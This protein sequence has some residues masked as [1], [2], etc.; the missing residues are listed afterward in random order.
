[1]HTPIH[2]AAP[3]ARQF[4]AKTICTPGLSR[5]QRLHT[6]LNGAARLFGRASGRLLDLQPRICRSSPRS[7]TP[8]QPVENHLSMGT[9]VSAQAVPEGGVKRAPRGRRRGAHFGSRLL[10]RE[11]Q[12]A[13][14]QLRR[15]KSKLQHAPRVAGEWNQSQGP[16]EKKIHGESDRGH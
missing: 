16:A 1:M 11:L 3:R 7:R 4:S 8:L 10:S 9:Q 13:N 2:S 12:R 6:S 14:S 5:A 15:P